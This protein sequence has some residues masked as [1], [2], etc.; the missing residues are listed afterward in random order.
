MKIFEKI[1]FFFR[2][3]EHFSLIYEKLKWKKFESKSNLSDT[4]FAIWFYKKIIGKDL[5]L[6]TPETFDEKLWYL[7]IYNKDPLLTK[8][9]DKF[10]VREY[11][12]ECGLENILNELYG[13]YDNANEIDF[14]NIPADRVFFK[15]NHTSGYNVI[16]DKNVFFDKKKFVKKFNFILKKNH[17]LLSREW[18]Y[19]NIHPKIL[20]EKMLPVSVEDNISRN[21]GLV[22]YRFLCFDGVVKCVF[23]DINTCAENGSHRLDA[24]RNVYDENFNFIDVKVSRGQFDPTLLKRPKNYDVM[25]KYAEILSAPFPFARVDL[26]NIDG[27]IFFGEIT[28]YHAAA[29]NRISPIQWDYTLGSWI[30]INNPKIKFSDEQI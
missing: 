25:K 7:K 2:E 14:N 19:K 4:D 16:Y 29:C 26:Y 24:L 1:K 11:V 5:N 6:V 23:A 10:L 9:T 22:D 21:T 17:Y 27:N 28:F 18:N 3:N 13:V 20:C 8:C 30:N 12:K 15:C